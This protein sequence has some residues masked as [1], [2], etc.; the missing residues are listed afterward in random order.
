MTRT[1]RPTDRRPGFLNSA[2]TFDVRQRPISKCAPQMGRHANRRSL[3]WKSVSSSIRAS[4]PSSTRRSIVPRGG[5]RTGAD[6]IPSWARERADDRESTWAASTSCES[7]STITSA[8]NRNPEAPRGTGSHEYLTGTGL[9]R[10]YLEAGAAASRAIPAQIESGSTTT[11]RRASIPHGP[12][13]AAKQQKKPQRTLRPITS[14]RYRYR[15]LTA[16]LDK[17]HVNPRDTSPS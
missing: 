9:S 4:P 16:F 17:T 5:W 14:P 1:P 3:Q 7:Q 8:S 2:P 10:R 15:A 11:V 12:E 13:P 6:P